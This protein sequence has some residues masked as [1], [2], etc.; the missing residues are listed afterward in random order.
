MYIYS[1][2]LAIP[3]AIIECWEKIE[4][5]VAG[6]SNIMTGNKI[7][8]AVFF[9]GPSLETQKRFVYF[10]FDLLSLFNNLII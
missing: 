8:N 3:G 10:V 6:I 9:G 5:A 4:K 2:I 7:F 1:S